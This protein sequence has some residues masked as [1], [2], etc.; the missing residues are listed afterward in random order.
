MI[1]TTRKSKYKIK[2]TF[3]ERHSPSH[4]HD[5]HNWLVTQFGEGGRNKHLRWRYGWMR[6]DECYYFKDEK[7]ASMF[8]LKW[9]K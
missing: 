7:A 5:I 4:R 9:S 6:D 3:N 8:L 2:V 1:T